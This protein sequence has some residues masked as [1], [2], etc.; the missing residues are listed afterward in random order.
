MMFGKKHK[1]ICS[2]WKIK[3][4]K[5]LGTSTGKEF[6]EYFENKVVSFKYS[7]VGTNSALD[8]VF[9]KGMADERKEWLENYDK[10]TFLIQAKVK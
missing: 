3:Y 1:T 2:K 4:Y 6:K 5:G 9:D 8:L 7:G 10:S